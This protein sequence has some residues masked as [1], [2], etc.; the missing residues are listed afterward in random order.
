MRDI[1]AKILVNPY[2]R[3]VFVFTGF[4]IAAKITYFFL[5][6]LVARLT[7]K[8][9]TQLDDMILSRVKGPIYYLIILA[10][11][12]AALNVLPLVPVVKVNLSRVLVSIVIAI[13]CYLAAS[14]INLT[15][16]TWFDQ[17]KTI[18]GR[19]KGQ[20][21]III[22]RKILNFII[23][24]LLFIF[25]LK[26]WQIE[27]T[28]LIAS[29]GIAGFILGFALKDI[30]A[31]IF[32]GVALIADKSF[33]IGDF[34]K[35]DTGEMGEI[36]DIGLRSTRIKSFEEGNEIIVP[37]STLVMTKITNYGRP[38]VHLKMVI[39]IGVAYGSD[40]GKVK[41]ILL[42]CVRKLKE[43]LEDPP[44][45]VYFMEMADFSL[46]FRIVFW[47]RDYR[48]RFNIQDRV[49]SSAYQELQ[50]QGIKIP[51]PTRT[52]YLEK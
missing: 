49:I 3:A 32:G 12:S 43:V 50:A 19:A 10:G 45:N 27:V 37:N 38:L 2:A 40:V 7:R 1:L 51:F 17:R 34:I 24:V 26:L 42:D 39:N 20:E 4:F 41:E 13:S 8:T 52:I 30:F 11:L 23:F 18:L 28:P 5:T 14:I 31:N 21:L 6:H 15:V 22:S 16:R 29:L 46:N 44:P 33:K 47:I 35:L 9:T 48:D 25:I 36:I